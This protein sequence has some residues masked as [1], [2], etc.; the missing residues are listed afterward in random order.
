MIFVSVK[1]TW[2]PHTEHSDLS[3]KDREKLPDSVHAFPQGAQGAADR[4]LAGQ[5]RARPL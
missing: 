1:P 4:L 2:K 5:E 3:T